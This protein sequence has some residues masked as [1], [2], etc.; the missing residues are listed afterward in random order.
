MTMKTNASIRRFIAYQKQAHPCA[1]TKAWDRY[2]IYVCCV[3]NTE[4]PKTF[5]DWITS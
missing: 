4:T 2:E 1:P 3:A 5:K